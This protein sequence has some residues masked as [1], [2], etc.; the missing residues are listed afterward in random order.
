[1]YTYSTNCLGPSHGEWIEKNGINWVGGRI[2]IYGD[3]EPYPDEINVPLINVY[4][5][6]NLSILLDELSTQYKF[7]W[8][9]INSLYEKTNPKIRF[10]VDD[11]AP[12]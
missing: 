6:W 12:F 5:W 1:M 10:F 2:Y 11:E 7:S 3:D 4:D 8:Q 9:E